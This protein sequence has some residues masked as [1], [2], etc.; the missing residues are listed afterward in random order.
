MVWRIGDRATFELLRRSGR[1]ARRGPVTVTFAQ[2][3]SAPEPRV[4]YAVGRKVGNAV[5]RNRV[6][7]RL[8]AAVAQ[9]A[10]LPPGAY[11]VAAGPAAARQ[12]FEELRRDVARA[13]TA[14]SGRDPA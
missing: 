13:M 3:G 2:A 1:R 6:R 4:A 5:L 14:A 10:E 12:S 11:L 8:R 7:R 9:T